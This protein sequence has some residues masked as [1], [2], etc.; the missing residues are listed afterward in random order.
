MFG[1]VPLQSVADAESAS[2]ATPQEEE[3]TV[4]EVAFTDPTELSV[5]VAV[6]ET[7][8]V[9]W[10]VGIGDPLEQGCVFDAVHEPPAPLPVE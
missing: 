5:V 1:P 4:A 2:S 6:E 8:L 3:A 9:S 7:P 10:P